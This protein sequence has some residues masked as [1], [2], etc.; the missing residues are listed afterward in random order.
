MRQAA[1]RHAAEPYDG[2]LESLPGSTS[3]TDRPPDPRSSAWPV[4]CDV[5]SILS[6]HLVKDV[7]TSLCNIDVTLRSGMHE[8]LRDTA[9]LSVLTLGERI[10]SPSTT[11]AETYSLEHMYV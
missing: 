1:A 7:A 4:E 8:Q 10:P 5:L 6:R 11:D 3:R 9:E 2:H